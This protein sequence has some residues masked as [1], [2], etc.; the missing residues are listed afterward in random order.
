[1]KK[2]TLLILALFTLLLLL[3]EQGVAQTYFNG[4]GVAEGYMAVTNQGTFRFYEAKANGTEYLAM[5]AAAAMGA[6]YTLTWPAADAAGALQSNGAGTLSWSANIAGNAATATALAADPA[7]CIAGEVA[8]GIAASGAAE[9]TAN[10]SVTTITGALTGN[11]STASALAADPADC[12]AGT[13]S[14]GINASGVAQCTAVPTVTAITTASV[15]TSGAVAG[16]TYTN[17]GTVRHGIAQ[18]T[19]PHDALIVG[20]AN[21]DL[22]LLTL[23]AKTAVYRV[24]A[25]V[26]EAFVLGAEAGMTVKCGVSAGGAE[27]L[28]SADIDAAVAVFGDA[29][30]EEGSSIVNA[31]NQIGPA[32][33]WTGDTFECRFASGGINWG[34]GATTASTAGSATIYVEY[35]VYP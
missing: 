31:G 14:T 2:V 28:A 19:V 33:Y 30:A 20:A 7:N 35:A 17:L 16:V 9:C 6:T 25:D 22:S 23:P 34:D 4:P 24:V 18:I 5:K 27:L 11:A 32:I 26:T 13:I 3:P 15:L 21:A 1:M 10:P 29:I 8:L 12:I